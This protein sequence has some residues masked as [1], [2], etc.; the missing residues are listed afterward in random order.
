MTNCIIYICL[1]L[2]S[3]KGEDDMNSQN[4][5]LKPYQS[6][7]SALSQYAFLPGFSYQLRFLATQLAEE[8]NWKYD[9]MTIPEKMKEEEKEVLR[10]YTVLYQYIHYTFSKALKE[11]RIV[12]SD[13]GSFSIMNTGL[14]AKST[15]EEIFMLFK[16]NE[17]LDAKQKMILGGFYKE[18]SRDIPETLRGKLPDHID[19]FENCPE[20]SYFNTRLDIQTSAE[21]IVI[22]NFERLP[23]S[24]QS[25]GDT[26]T[27]VDIVNGLIATAKKRILRN[28]RLVVPHY[29]NGKIQ[30]LAPLVFGKDTFVLVLEKNDQSYR[31]NTILTVGMAYCDARLITKPESAWLVLEPNQTKK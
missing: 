24:L 25:I 4:N 18:S 17:K 12:E 5:S 13:D 3:K 27:I 22:D 8:E 26:R 10:N 29:Y 15:G 21:H 9:D 31:A 2:S 16:K 6:R 23:T 28:N 14:L 19:Y 20:D 1:S 11:S 7:R 30:Y